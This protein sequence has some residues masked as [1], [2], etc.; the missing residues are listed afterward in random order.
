MC[1]IWSK[2]HLL[3]V[4]TTVA[5]ASTVALPPWPLQCPPLPPR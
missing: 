4:N 5:S 2:H 1:E 3:P